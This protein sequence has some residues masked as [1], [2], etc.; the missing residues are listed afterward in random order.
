MDVPQTFHPYTAVKQTLIL[1]DAWFAGWETQFTPGS[2]ERRMR[3]S[4]LVVRRTYGEWMVPGLWYRGLREVLKRIGLVLPLEPR[5]PEWWA[6]GW[7]RLRASLADTALQRWTAH[8]IG[9]VG[10]KP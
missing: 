5:G 4:G 10:E 7:E 8:V 9:T 6:R 3:E 1:F 2:L